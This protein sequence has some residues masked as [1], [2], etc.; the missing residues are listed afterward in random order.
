MSLGSANDGRGVQWAGRRTELNPSHT[1]ARPPS[2]HHR[3]HVTDLLRLRLPPHPSR[4]SGF[5]AQFPVLARLHGEPPLRLAQR[6]PNYPGLHGP[7]PP[8]KYALTLVTLFSI[9]RLF[10]GNLRICLSPP[11]VPRS[12]PYSLCCAVPFYFILG[13]YKYNHP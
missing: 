2:S 10:I 8:S 3:H 6:V 4:T 5:R 11:L 7:T 12:Q 1:T 13:K 9:M